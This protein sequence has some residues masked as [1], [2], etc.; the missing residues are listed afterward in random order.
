M[1]GGANR[2]GLRRREL[3]GDET[4]FVPTILTGSAY[5]IVLNK[6]HHN[7]GRPACSPPFNRAITQNSLRRQQNCHKPDK[8]HRADYSRKTP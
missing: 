4:E 3:A 1:P 7:I 6:H 2:V 5:A 8:S